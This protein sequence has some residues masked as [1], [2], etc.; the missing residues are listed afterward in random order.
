MSLA[1]LRSLA[2]I[3]ADEDMLHEDSS[4]RYVVSKVLLPY[5]K[6]QWGSNGHL[7]SALPASQIGPP[8]FYVIHSW[9][10]DFFDLVSQLCEQLAPKDLKHKGQPWIEAHATS[11]PCSY[12]STF[13]WLDFLSVSHQCE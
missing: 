11:S 9:G 6:K 3:L 12:S 13:V 8:S 7:W 10:G 4:T 2:A 1:W 5:V